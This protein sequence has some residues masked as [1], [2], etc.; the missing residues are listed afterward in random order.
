M[1]NE[2]LGIGGGLVTRRRNDDSLLR[3]MPKRLSQK[4]T[5]ASLLHC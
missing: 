1:L 4:G 2:A 5:P 3:L